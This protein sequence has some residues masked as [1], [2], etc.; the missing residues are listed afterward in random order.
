MRDVV[1]IFRSIGMHPME[2]A[3]KAI[4]VYQKKYKHAV[5]Q[6]VDDP[7]LMRVF[8]DRMVCFRI[9]ASIVRK[10]IKQTKTAAAA[11]DRESLEIK[12]FFRDEK[13]AR[14]FA[15]LVAEHQS[16]MLAEKTVDTQS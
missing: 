10:A 3:L 4:V 11:I 9:C 1:G 15:G 12:P 6:G 8:T 2:E 16:R 13:D 5:N 7:S 14:E